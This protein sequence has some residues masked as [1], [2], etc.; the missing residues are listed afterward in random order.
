[1]AASCG[2]IEMETDYEKKIKVCVAFDE[3]MSRL[4]YAKDS[5]LRLNELT[6]ASPPLP[7]EKES[8]DMKARNTFLRGAFVTVMAMWEGYVQDLLEES[9]IIVFDPDAQIG[10]NGKNEIIKRSDE[11]YSSIVVTGPEAS[12]KPHELFKAHILKK[13]TGIMPVFSG[14][15]G[16]D[17]QFKKI[18][19][20]TGNL[21]DKI[22]V[23]HDFVVPGS[24]KVTLTVDRGEGINDIIRLYYGVRCAFAHGHSEKTFKEGGALHGYPIE[25]DLFKIVNSEHIEKK[26]RQLY[27][28][29]KDYGS[30]AWVHYDHLVN[31]QRFVIA[32]AFQ[33]FK[34]VSCFILE[35]YELAIWNNPKYVIENYSDN[36]YW[37]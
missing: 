26:L 36:V 21:S 17:E 23:V 33:L 14:N 15:R 34:A 10:I 6:A 1:M 30:K 27:D 7:G 22:V 32:L 11:Y 25:A 13:A 9:G 16:I 2:R 24:K 12:K 3:L 28:N 19:N 35:K 5:I 20:F 37:Y 4:E 29:V 31:L 18:F 8:L